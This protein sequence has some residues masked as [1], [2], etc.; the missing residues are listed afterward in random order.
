M[1]LLK[2]YGLAPAFRFKSSVLL[3]AML[4]LRINRTHRTGTVML[5][6]PGLLTTGTKEERGLAAGMF[7]FFL[8]QLL[9]N[10]PHINRNGTMMPGCA[11]TGMRAASQVLGIFVFL[12]Y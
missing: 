12:H 11:T 7:L 6:L 9:M 5:Q 1:L 2:N 8:F 3:V 10:K 4:H